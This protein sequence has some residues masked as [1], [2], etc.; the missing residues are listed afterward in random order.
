MAKAKVI[1]KRAETTLEAT[2]GVM[3]FGDLII[4]ELSH[5]VQINKESISLSPKEYDLLLYLVKNKGIALSREKLLDNIW[6]YSYDGD[7]RTVDTHIKRLREKLNEKAD[8]VATVRG[9][10]Y[11]FEVKE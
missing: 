3:T 2:D 1:L 5:D 7:L 10:G 6:G 8:L 4:N 9:S 11:K